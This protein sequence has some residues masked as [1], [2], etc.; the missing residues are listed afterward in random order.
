[1]T[2]PC[3]ALTLAALPDLSNGRWKLLACRYPS[4]SVVAATGEFAA[5]QETWVGANG[6]LLTLDRVRGTPGVVFFV[7][8]LGV[9]D[10][11][12]SALSCGAWPGGVCGPV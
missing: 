3:P 6:S 8:C 4:A 12:T 7:W 10:D 1:V 11:P 2:S 5:R 9:R